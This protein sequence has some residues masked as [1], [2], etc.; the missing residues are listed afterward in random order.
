[1]KEEGNNINLDGMALSPSAVANLM[2]N[3]EKTGYFKSVEMKETF[4][5]DQVKDIQAFQFTLTCEKAQQPQAAQ[6]LQQAQQPQQQAQQP[7]PPQQKS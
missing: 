4:Q 6:P 3:L 1:M 5:D 2:R 7:Q